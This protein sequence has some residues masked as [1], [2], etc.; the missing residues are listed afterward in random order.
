MTVFFNVL[1]EIITREIDYALYLIT[2]GRRNIN[3]IDDNV[4]YLP[5]LSASKQGTKAEILM[6][7]KRIEKKLVSKFA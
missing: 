1:H 5:F 3:S 4:I 2:L 7:S 6:R